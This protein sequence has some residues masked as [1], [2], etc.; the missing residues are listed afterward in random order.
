MRAMVQELQDRLDA[1]ELR[2]D[3]LREAI[4]VAGKNRELQDRRQAQIVEAAYQ[5]FRNPGFHR[6]TVNDIARRAGIDKR[7]LYDYVGDKHDILYLL[8]LSYLP[9]EL[10]R[11]AG[12]VLQNQQPIEQ[13]KNLIREHLAFIRAN[14]DLVLLSYREMRYLHRG[15]ISNLLWLIDEIMAVYDFVL[16]RGMEMGVMRELNPRIVGH[17]V[18]A[19]LDM[20]GLS[21]WDLDRFEDEEIERELMILF[22]NGL[23]S[24][25]FLGRESEA[26]VASGPKGGLG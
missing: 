17:A 7:T 3:Q 12:A 18:R 19:G 22:L 10:E 16:G 5:E 2:I 24:P 6:T 21:S 15:Q 20:P 14:K 11:L 23:L 25:K 26:P 1:A 13:I 9:K 8:F 4:P